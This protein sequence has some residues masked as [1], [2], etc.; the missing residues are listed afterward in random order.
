[1]SEKRDYYEVLGLEK[2]ASDARWR[3]SSPSWDWESCDYRIK[4]QEPI[5]TIEKW[6]CKDRQGDFSI[7]ESSN[8]DKYE[9]YKKLK[10]IESYEVEL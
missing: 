4:E 5:I 1:M 6:L 10:L 8:I 7:V 2:G 3:L 9:I